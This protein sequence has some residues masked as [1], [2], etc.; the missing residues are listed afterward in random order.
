MHK[1]QFP[2]GWSYCEQ[3]R[4]T[5]SWKGVFLLYHHPKEKCSRTTFISCLQFDQ[6]NQNIWIGWKIRPTKKVLGFDDCCCWFGGAALDFAIVQIK[7]TKR[8][9]KEQPDH[10]QPLEEPN[11][12]VGT[13]CLVLESGSKNYI[14]V[15]GHH[16]CPSGILYQH[17]FQ[18]LIHDKMFSSKYIAL[19]GSSM[20]I[21]CNILVI[22]FM[23]RGVYILFASDIVTTKVEHYTQQC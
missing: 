13:N 19:R 1:Y 11:E 15:I 22:Y 17:F 14:H 20:K 10:K 3:E 23:Y 7:K 9:C 21:P 8:L 4:N 12:W 2:S 6:I 18:Y 16:A 5:P